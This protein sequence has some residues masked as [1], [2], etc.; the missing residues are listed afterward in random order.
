MFHI[1][2]KKMMFKRRLVAGFVAVMIV[3]SSVSPAAF[4]QEATSTPETTEVAGCMDETALD[5][6]ELATI[7]DGTCTYETVTETASSTPESGA[8]PDGNDGVDGEVGGSA[9]S[10]DDGT[11]TS[12]DDGTDGADTPDGA[13][14]GAGTSTDDGVGTPAGDGDGTKGTDGP[15]GQDGVGVEDEPVK[16][17][18][19][20][21]SEIEIGEDATPDDGEGVTGEIRRTGSNVKITTGN[22]T[23]QGEVTNDVNS[24]LVRSEVDVS[25]PQHLNL[26]TF[27]ATGTNDAVVATDGVAF[28]LTGN[29]FA[30]SRSL[31]GGAGGVSTITTGDSVAA[32][33]I[34]NVVNTNV[35]NSD[36]FL[37]LKNQITEPGQSLNLTSFFFP[38]PVENKLLATQC[39]LLSCRSEDV[40]Y[41]FTQTNMATVTND[42]FIESVTG[43]NTAQGDYLEIQTG[44]ARGGANV[45]NVVNTNIVDSNY[46][47]L[48]YNALGNLDGD[49]IL[50]TQ[51]LFHDFFS[52][53][54]GMTQLEA[55][56]DAEGININISN[57][58]K[59]LVNNDVDTYAETGL[60]DIDTAFD[61]GIYT[62]KSAS[63]SNILNKINQ[64]TFGGD[65]MM[66]QI[67]VHGDWSGDLHGL[68][69]GL[70]W[71]WAYDANGIVISI[72]N[73]GDEI[74]RS[75]RL[76]YDMDSYRANVIDHN[77]VLID[78]N[79]NIEANSGENIIDGVVGNVRTGDA[80]AS[81]NLMNIA[82][83]NIIGANWTYAVINIF[84][85]FDGNITFS[86]T[87]IGVTGSVTSPANPVIP[88][89]LLNY[90]YNVSN[91]SDKVA[92]NVTLRQT[93]QNA[94]A[95]GN[96][97]QQ[98]VNVGTL[99]PG[100]TKV[101]NL[102]ARPRTDLASGTFSVVATAVVESAESDSN[103]ANNAH[104]LV[105]P[106]IDN[107]IG[108]GT[109]TPPSGGNDETATSTDQ[110]SGGVIV[111]PPPSS[112]G[113]GGGGGGGDGS[114]HTKKDVERVQK[115]AIDPNSAPFLV[116]KKFANLDKD[117]IVLAG[118]AVDYT[119]VLTNKGGQAYDAVVYDVLKSDIGAVLSEQS[120][121][122]GTILAGEVIELTYTTEYDFKTP[123]GTYTNTASVEGYRHADSKA[124]GAKPL[125]IDS[126][127]HKV[128]VKGVPLAVG[129][130]SV[131]AVFP[132]VN[133]DVSALVSWETSKSAL[134]QVFYG[135]KMPWNSYNEKLPNYGYQNQSFKFSKPKERH[136]MIIKGLKPG[137]QYAYRFDAK[138]TEH[139]AVSREY[140]FTIPKSVNGLAISVGQNFLTIAELRARIT[141]VPVPTA[142]FTAAQAPAYVPPKPA[143]TPEPTPEPVAPSPAP[144]PA[145]TSIFGKVKSFFG[146]GN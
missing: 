104:V 53:P 146:F 40:L 145:N 110:G 90:T 97:N 66:L 55:L 35:V 57:T 121:E 134:S 140:D 65:S 73:A 125:T 102:S 99:T 78:N 117:D 63:E 112:G 64:N 13:D 49:L 8:G 52:R 43:Q 75:P 67:R 41:N 135:E 128:E 10:T 111:T 5:F 48:T 1:Y 143:P 16:I 115:E 84:G 103:S 38:D 98:L 139:Q 12:T 83:A 26:Y 130:V 138:S 136:F 116:I 107:S 45:I 95:T 141:G 6:N 108:G 37:Y 79:I 23:A 44:N 18:I 30:R 51:E 137:T 71:D 59:A 69:A 39:T 58:N 46:R 86:A 32:I 54:N 113:G 87:D 68:P 106:V 118:Q 132:G 109:T 92:T 124:K 42:V 27:N 25:G 126:A 20:V 2:S 24:N 60:N 129:N 34:A 33:N 101:V 131:M 17:P 88:G 29:N 11:G 85:D 19:P 91:S 82:N 120:W 70:D 89:S 74:A 7:D 81:A 94:Y 14:D 22:A 62:G 133:G 142:P 61:S 50:P 21:L 56:G 15:D 36:G 72:F 28:A 77:T 96:T 3:L 47:L 105:T 144:A 119:I 76:R 4:A 80:I 31:S 122:L 127:V 123:S 9:S 93:L 100:Q 114:K